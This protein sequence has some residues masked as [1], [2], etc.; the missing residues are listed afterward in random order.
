MLDLLIGMLGK[1]LSRD[2]DLGQGGIV[3]IDS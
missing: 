2:S 3:S 1:A